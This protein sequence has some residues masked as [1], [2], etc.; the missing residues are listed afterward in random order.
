M[1]A[2]HVHSGWEEEMADHVEGG[3]ETTSW[4]EKE[5]QALGEGGAKVTRATFAQRFSGGIEAETVSETVMTYREDGTADF[6]GYVRVNGRLSGRP[7]TF[8]LQNVGAFD[9]KEVKAETEV[10]PGSATGE[11]T[12]LSGKGT[13]AAPLGSTGRYSLDFSVG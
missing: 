5:C 4:D 10:V 2:A 12:G 8:V 11:L 7:G 3:F 13:Y 6:V 9:G 1:Y